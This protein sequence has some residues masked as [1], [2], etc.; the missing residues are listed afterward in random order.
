MQKTWNKL[1]IYRCFQKLSKSRLSNHST[2]SF[3]IGGGAGRPFH[4]FFTIQFSSTESPE[5]ARDSCRKSFG[6]SPSMLSC[7]EIP[8]KV[9][10][11]QLSTISGRWMSLFLL[12]PLIRFASNFP[13][14]FRRTLFL[15]T[16]RSSQFLIVSFATSSS[17][18]G[19]NF[20]TF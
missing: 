5:I 11:A 15:R 18:N 14:D 9:G 10:L 16:Q 17:F 3:G 8:S 20:L 2:I 19:S 7:L 6:L 4:G 12:L 1:F 13:V